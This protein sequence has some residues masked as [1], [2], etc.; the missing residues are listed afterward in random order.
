MVLTEGLQ[1][2]MGLAI[3]LFDQLDGRRCMSISLNIGI[4]FNR[5]KWKVFGK[6]YLSAFTYRST[7]LAFHLKMTN[8]RNS[9]FEIP[10]AVY[11]II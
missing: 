8:G 3:N 9:S 6:R 2:Q 11:I 1:E 5:K 7:Q 4:D 10:T